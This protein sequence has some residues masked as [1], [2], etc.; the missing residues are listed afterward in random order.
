MEQ[1]TAFPQERQLHAPDPNDLLVTDG[2]LLMYTGQQRDL[3]IPE[4]IASQPVRTIGMGAFLGAPAMETVA[5]GTG[6]TH[7]GERAFYKCPAL[8]SVTLTDSV[9]QVDAHAF[10]ECPALEEIRI[11][12]LPLPRSSYEQ[13]LAGC[14]HL[15]DGTVLS[16]HQPQHPLISQILSALN[17]LQP[18]AWL[19]L[20]LP[21]LFREQAREDAIRAEHLRLPRKVFSSTDTALLSEEQAVMQLIRSGAPQ[22]RH[23]DAE[24]EHDLMAR[25]EISL[26]STPCC[27]FS[28]DNV[29]ATD[30]TGTCRADVRIRI[31][32]H[33]WPSVVR[34]ALDGTAYYIY[35]RLYTNT[36][37]KRCY[38]SRDIAVYTDKGLVTDQAE[39]RRVYAK[40]I[41]PAL[42]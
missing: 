24:T 30:A 37:S 21:C 12:A 33:Y 32:R 17:N 36:H 3:Y 15:P 38:L 25:Q 11:N 31:G 18:A 6:I 39:S 34:V 40:Y 5:I 9:T 22:A 16:L 10:V 1:Q 19:P 23:P 13:Y 41:L 29:T 14:S 42:L 27:I 4:T 7:I 8:T 35:R 2:V 28:L 20:T 26:P